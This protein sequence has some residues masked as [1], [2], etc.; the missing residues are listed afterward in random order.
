MSSPSTLRL[1]ALSILR[2]GNGAN[3]SLRLEMLNMFMTESLDRPVLEHTLTPPRC[4]VT[5]DRKC[6]QDAQ[7]DEQ[8]YRKR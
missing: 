8:C 3:D 6:V 4:L 2:N 5:P 1:Y 7:L